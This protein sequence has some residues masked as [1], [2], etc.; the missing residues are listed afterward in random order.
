MRGMPEDEPRFSCVDIL[1]LPSEDMAF[2]MVWLAQGTQKTGT[3]NS[4]C[5]DGG[6][7]FP[8]SSACEVAEQARK[9]KK[10]TK[11]KKRSVRIANS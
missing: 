8:K 11:K 1:Q 6:V 9:K 10:T 7:K 2:Q 5:K 3:D 4:Q